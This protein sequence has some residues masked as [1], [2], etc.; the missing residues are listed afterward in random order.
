[1]QEVAKCVQERVVVAQE[2]AVR[3]WVELARLVAEYPLERR[4][5]LGEAV[6]V[7]LVRLARFRAQ[8]RSCHPPRNPVRLGRSQECQQASGRLETCA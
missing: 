6:V 7:Y 1:V 2:Q 8:E 3:V 5:V 4:W